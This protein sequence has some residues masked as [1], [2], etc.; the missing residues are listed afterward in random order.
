MKIVLVKN[1]KYDFESIVTYI[2]KDNFPYV[3]DQYVVISEPAEIEFIMLDNESITNQE[4]DII[5]GQITKV[6]ADSEAAITA[7]NG[8]KQELLALTCES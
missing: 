7:L 6:M 4:I 8:R 5:D 1:V 3:D 2:S